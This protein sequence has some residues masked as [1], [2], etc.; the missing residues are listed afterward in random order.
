L[1]PHELALVL[2]ALGLSV[3]TAASALGL[4]GGAIISPFLILAIGL[5]PRLAIGTTVLGVFAAIL[6]ASLAYVRQKRVDFKLALLFDALDV[7][8]VA[9]G[10]YLTVVLLPEVLACSLGA[11]LL[12]SGIRLAVR[13]L[14]ATFRERGRPLAA[15]SQEEASNGAIWRRTIVDKDGRAYSY[16]LSKAGLMTAILGS[17]FSG[18]IS[19][20]LGLGGGLTDLSLMLLLGVPMEVAM[21]TAMFGML[22]TRVS[23]VVAHILLGNVKIELAAPLAFG[24]LIGGQLGPRIASK[25]RPEVL[26]LVFSSIVLALGFVLLLRSALSLASMLSP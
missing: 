19:G 11:F 24:A 17:F 20:M 23:S 18:L 3:T 7:L 5:E 21:A 14:R 8:G 10:A 16:G 6:S 13:T 22:L 2:F 1:A 15:S 25:L 4:A 9:L 26:K 12:Y